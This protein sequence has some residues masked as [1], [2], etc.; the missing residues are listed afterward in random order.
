M[1]SAEVVAFPPSHFFTRPRGPSI[2][3]ATRVFPGITQ[4]SC[5]RGERVL[6]SGAAHP[7]IASDAPART[8]GAGWTSKATAKQLTRTPHE[9]TTRGDEN[10][11][12]R[13]AGLRCRMA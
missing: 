4:A 12:D 9:R 6:R 5:K 8:G 13:N 1:L 2:F 7:I 11:A 3:T 10:R